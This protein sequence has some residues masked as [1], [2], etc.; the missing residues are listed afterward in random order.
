MTFTEDSLNCLISSTF[1]PVRMECHM[2]FLN[3]FCIRGNTKRSEPFY[4]CP[5]LDIPEYR[6][7]LSESLSE[8]DISKING[9]SR[10]YQRLLYV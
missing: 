3:E 6:R 7:T 1:L 9:S 4:E 10:S 8:E 2:L 5:K